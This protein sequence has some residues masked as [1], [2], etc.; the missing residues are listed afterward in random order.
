MKRYL[1]NGVTIPIHAGAGFD[2]VTTPVVKDQKAGPGFVTAPEPV[3]TPGKS[4]PLAIPDPLKPRLRKDGYNDAAEA[5]FAAQ[6]KL[7]DAYKKENPGTS[8]NKM[9]ADLQQMHPNVF[10]D[11][12]DDD[13]EVDDQA[14]AGDARRR[15][16]ANRAVIANFRAGR[17]DLSADEVFEILGPILQD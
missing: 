3:V 12:V 7:I 5:R 14:N 16:E 2:I 17:P 8:T 4:Y 10:N 15:V 1:V 11:Y 13:D 6:R 9:F